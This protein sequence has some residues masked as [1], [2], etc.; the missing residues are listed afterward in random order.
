LIRAVQSCVDSGTCDET[1]ANSTI[2]E[3]F[4]LFSYLGDE[5]DNGGIILK[6]MR[7]TEAANPPST[8]ALLPE[9]VAAKLKQFWFRYR[10]NC[11]GR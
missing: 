6:A 2:C 3:D 8:I 5:Y 9:M 7:T 10:T 4:A 1:I 11:G